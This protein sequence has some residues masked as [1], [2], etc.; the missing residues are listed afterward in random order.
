MLQFTAL[1]KRDRLPLILFTLFLMVFVSSSQIMIL[2]PIL[3]VVGKTLD[4]PIDKLSSLFSATAIM[5]G[6]FALLMGPIS[7]R[8]GRRK[9]VLFGTLAM[10]ITLLLHPLAT[11]YWSLFGIRLLTGASAGILSGSAV[12][13]VGDYFPINKRGW[14][15]GWI[16]SGSA[17]GQILGIPIGSL[18]AESTVFYAP[19]ILFAII[20]LIVVLLTWFYLPQPNVKLNTSRFSGKEIISQYKKILLTKGVFVGGIVFALMYFGLT[21]YI[22]Y[23]PAWLIK[24]C[25]ANCYQIAAI[26][27]VGGVANLISGPISGTL[28]DKYGRKKIIMISCLGS[29]V[30]MLISATVIISM[31]LAFLLFG[32]I[33]SFLAM[34]TSPFQSLLTEFVTSDNRGTMMSTCVAMG[35]VG[36]T[37]AGLIAGSVYLEIGFIGNSITGATS[38]II[39]GVLVWRILPESQ[40]VSNP[41]PQFDTS[42]Q[43]LQINYAYLKV[44]QNRK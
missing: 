12:S 17:A 15:N 22:V 27:F 36:M 38:L 3:P 31:E 21:M 37:I 8:I 4:I 28:S 41:S 30:V 29:A 2:V 1:G 11:G 39:A 6:V 35:Q 40:I 16:M 25:E 34:R 7:D 23:M 42:E 19:F 14:A 32:M 20:M 18:L 5:V 13:F 10:F 33:M 24:Y 43:Q 26:F 44:P 9:I